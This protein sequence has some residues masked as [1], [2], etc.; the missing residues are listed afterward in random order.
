MRRLARPLFTV[1]AWISLL[2]AAQPLNGADAKRIEAA[3]ARVKA[4]MLVNP[5]DALR[6]GERAASLARRL[7]DPIRRRLTLATIDWLR[8]EASLRMEQEELAA[9]LI[10]SALREVEKIAPRSKLHGDVLLTNGRLHGARIDVATALLNYHRAFAIFREVGDNR[11]QSLALLTL[12]TL[13]N[14]ADENETALR[15]SAQALSIYDSDPQLSLSSHNN[16]G[17]MLADL[18]RYDEAQEQFGQ[19]LA[20]ARQVGSNLHR[21]GV[22]VNMA[23]AYLKQGRLAEADRVLTESVAILRTGEAEAWRSQVIAAS[24]QAAFQRHDLSSAVASIRES[25]DDVDLATTPLWYRDAHRTAYDIFHETGDAASALPHLEALKRIDDEAAK[26]ASSLNTALVAARFDFANQELRIERFKAAELRRN[27]EVTREQARL[28]RIIFLCLGVATMVIIVLLLFGLLAIRRS[29]NA[30]QVANDGLELS[31]AAL[32]K[33]LAAK[34]EFLATTSHEIRTPLNGILGMTQVMLAD[35]GLPGAVRD[36]V[37]VVHGAGLTMRALVDDI[38]DMAKIETGNLAIEA[39]PFDC[40]ALVSDASRLWQDQARAKGLEF[41][42]D[43]DDCPA[44][45]EGD[46]VRVRQ[47]VSNLLSNAI[48]FTET[49]GIVLTTTRTA[50]GARYEIRIRDSGIGIASEQLRAVFESFR[51]ADAGTTRRFGGTGL[52]LAICRNL[53]RAM[54][55][56]V[57][58]ESVAGQG[59]TFILELPLKPVESVAVVPAAKPAVAEGRGVLI[60]ERNPITRSMIRALVEPHAARTA[61]A[62]DRAGA[63]A[64]LAQGGITHVVVDEATLAGDDE[65]FAAITAAA[66][67]EDAS[68]LLIVSDAATSYAGA[69]RVLVKPVTGARLVTALFVLPGEI[70]A[71]YPSPLSKAA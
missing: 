41:T 58:A 70:D 59:S 14:D 38:L 24:A 7:A 31:N 61:T 3:V 5:S 56:D 35:A 20:L 52:G 2:A 48:K 53:A 46:A 45:I 17:I 21:E 15:Y 18:G 40:R 4:A 1:T 36:R 63:V 66:R 55:G 22:L 23:R 47:V 64:C 65:A 32:G 43:L 29:R 30:T 44:T 27:V 69:E 60:V 6:E 42:L 71:G 13:Y 34:T 37:G 67:V 57:R 26:L 19:A 54:G 50:D 12:A 33:A 39:A 9:P 8:G 11:S 10:A 62:G 25:F 51:Q 68:V 49:G 16:R 28:Q